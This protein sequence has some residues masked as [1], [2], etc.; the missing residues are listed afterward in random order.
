LEDA[1]RKLIVLPA[2]AAFLIVGLTPTDA[3]I[4]AKAG[5]PLAEECAPN[6]GHQSPILVP[7]VPDAE[8]YKLTTRTDGVFFDLNADGEAEKIAWTAPD[9][10]LG[11][12]ARDRNGNGRID[13]GSELFST[14][15]RPDAEN[16]FAALNKMKLEVTMGE[17]Y[18]ATFDGDALFDTLLLWEDVNHNGLSERSELQAAHNVLTAIGFGYG[19]FRRPD[20]FG[21][22][23]N[24]QGW[25]FFKDDTPTFDPLAQ[26]E[27]DSKR[28]RIFDVNLISAR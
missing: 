16:G 5:M 19:T 8:P 28:R 18:A 27:I 22:V 14:V 6:C 23:L 17:T 12:L 11:F 26:H 1:V 9:S 2:F 3:S 20:E 21:N 13:N 7:L 15:T 24:M 25:A 10:Q 4:A